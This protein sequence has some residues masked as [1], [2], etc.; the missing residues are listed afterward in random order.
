VRDLQGTLL[1]ERMVGHIF[2]M[3]DGLV[4]RFDIR[5]P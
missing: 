4:K 5:N 3:E 2:W 1:A